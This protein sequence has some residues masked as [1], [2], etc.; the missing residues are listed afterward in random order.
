MKRLIAILCVLLTF[1]APAAFAQEANGPRVTLDPPT[2]TNKPGQLVLSATLVGPGGK[3][4]SDQQVQFYQRVD[5]FGPREAL[6]G[7]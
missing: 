5:L 2:R 7:S 4:L 1:G 6:L 3:L